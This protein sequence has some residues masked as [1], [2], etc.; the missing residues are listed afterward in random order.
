ML[1]RK[2]PNR[3]RYAKRQKIKW[4]VRV[5]PV[6]S[7]PLGCQET[8]LWHL[9]TVYRPSFPR[10]AAALGDTNSRD[11]HSA[12]SRLLIR[13]CKPLLAGLAFCC[14]PEEGGCVGGCA[15]G[16]NR[17]A[18]YSNYAHRGLGFY[19][20]FWLPASTLHKPL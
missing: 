18:A 10:Q 7:H 11:T 17:A 16:C 1:K 19:H 15:H 20:H 14:E 12:G 5:P 2:K 6:S 3:R 9:N 8:M 13:T 4:E